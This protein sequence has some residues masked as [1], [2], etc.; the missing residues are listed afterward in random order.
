CHDRT[1]T[2]VA[3]RRALAGLSAGVGD[4][5][6]RHPRRRGDLRRE[7][8]RGRVMGILARLTTEPRRPQQSR[9]GYSGQT[10]AGVPATPDTAVTIP[11]VWACLRYLS[12][13]VAILPWHVMREEKS[14][15]VALPTHS[16]DYI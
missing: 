1:R 13:T 8:R 6:R 10:V 16:L 3:G 5:A 9:V 4:R 12:Q 7:R 11:A 2:R 14:G 15:G